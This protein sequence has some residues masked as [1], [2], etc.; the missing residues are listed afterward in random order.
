MCCP[1]DDDFNS[2]YDTRYSLEAAVMEYSSF[3]ALDQLDKISQDSS[4]VFEQVRADISGVVSYGIDSYESCR[5]LM[6]KQTALIKP[7]M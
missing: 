4:L 6:W 1:D 3:S 2:I 7:I 5:L